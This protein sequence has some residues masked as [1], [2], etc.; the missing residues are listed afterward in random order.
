MVSIMGI[1][2]L[3]ISIDPA[4]SQRIEGKNSCIDCHRK[5]TGVAKVDVQYFQWKDSWHS[6]LGVT[7]DRCHSGH[8]EK[9]EKA[10]AHASLLE[11]QKGKTPSYFLALD[12]HCGK[13]HQNEFDSFKMSTH[14][15]FLQQSRGP[16]CTSCHHPKTGHTLTIDE[17][18]GACANCHNKQLKG[19]EFIP[20]ETQMVLVS[21]ERTKLIVDWAEEFIAV[22]D[23]DRTQKAWARSKVKGA[24]YELSQSNIQWHLFNLANIRKHID[25]AVKLAKEAKDLIRKKQ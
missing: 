3:V 21:M 13:C 6:A 23:A 7:C 15:R 20:T 2:T 1:F 11:A 18:S 5:P 24:R 14:F 12:R 17:I 8:P 22:S 19:F 10:A 9:D 16:N 25:Q 4:I